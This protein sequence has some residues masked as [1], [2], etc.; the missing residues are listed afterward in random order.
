M[1]LEQLFFLS[2]TIGAVAVVAA[3]CRPADQ[4]QYQG[5][6]ARRAQQ[7]HGAMDCGANGNRQQSRGRRVDD[8]RYSGRAALSAAERLRLDQFLQEQ[9]WACFHTWDRTQRDIFPKG[10]FELTG[11]AYLRSVLMTAGGGAWWRPAFVADVDALLAKS[12]E[13]A[14][15]A[16]QVNAS[17]EPA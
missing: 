13:N 16:A 8:R 10:T 11:G 5:T 3:L 6:A 1:T 2:Q 12:S 7:H 9:T 17:P 15:P 14:S 4:G